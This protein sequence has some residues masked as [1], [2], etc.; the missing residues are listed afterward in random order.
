MAKNW[1]VADMPAVFKSGNKEDMAD[2][3]NRFPLVSMLMARLY[4]AAPV[5]FE[6]FAKGIPDTVTVRKIEAVLKSGADVEDADE[7][8]ED[9]K[10][11]KKEKAADKKESKKSGKGKKEVKGEYDGMTAKELFT[12][13]KEKG[14]KVEPKKD[15]KYYIKAL[16]KAAAEA[17]EDA[18]EDDDWDDGEDEV[19]EDKKKKEK[20][21]KK[22]GSKKKKDEEDDDDEDEDWDI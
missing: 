9:V 20:E 7:T 21:S 2:V 4:E 6:E 1:T 12:L 14:I 15:E 8:E 18:E 13:C 11:E 5:A 19:K 17:E 22:S 3:G 16:E 10:E